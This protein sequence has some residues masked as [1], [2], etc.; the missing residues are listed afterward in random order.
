MNKVLLEMISDLPKFDEIL[1]RMRYILLF[2]VYVSIGF[3]PPNDN[4]WVFTA[5]SGNGFSG[6]S[7]Y[8]YLQTSQNQNESRSK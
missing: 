6:N 8:H 5:G 7:K 2:I 3:L 1:L 4:L